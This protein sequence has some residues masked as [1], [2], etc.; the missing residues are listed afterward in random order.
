MNWYLKALK[1]YAVFNGRA[2][3]AEYWTFFLF[4]FIISFVLGFIEGAL[5][6][7]GIIAFVYILACLIPGIAVSVRRLHDTDRSGWW[8]LISFVPIVGAIVLFVFMAQDS[9]PGQNRYGINPKEET[10]INHPAEIIDTKNNEEHIY[11]EVFDEIESGNLEKGLWAKILVENDGD[12][13]RTKIIYA[14][15]R[16]KR[17]KIEME[18]KNPTHKKCP[19]CCAI[20]KLDAI[21]CVECDKEM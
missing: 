1:K 12:E 9:K 14:R 17:I 20:N 13:N 8:L 7:Q 3:R 4:N 18:N 10:G 16:I 21:W 15:E 6:S 2:R 11:A 5:G 19:H